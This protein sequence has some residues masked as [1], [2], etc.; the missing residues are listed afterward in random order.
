MALRGDA[1]DL[2][3]LGLK[4]GGG[5]HDDVLVSRHAFVFGEQQYE[6][7]EQTSS[8]SVQVSRTTSGWVVRVRFTATI[9]GPCMRCFDDQGFTVEVDQT[10]VHE[11]QLELDS[12]YVEDNDFDLAGYV[13]DTIGLALPQSMSGELDADSDCLLCGRSRQE[14]QQIGITDQADTEG[15]DPRWAKLREL[16]L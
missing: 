2:E 5:W 4:S 8:I 15:A 9:N 14:L 3:K 13:H 7:S 12:E 16:E 11:P 10:E 1:I 6:P